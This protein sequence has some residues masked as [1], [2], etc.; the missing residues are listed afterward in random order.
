MN[1]ELVILSNFKIQLV[2]FLDELIEYFPNE[3]DFVIARIF[4]KDQIPIEEI[5]K[6]FCVKLCPLEEMIKNKN[7]KFFIENNILFGGLD[8]DKIGKINYFRELWI[9]G[10]IDED[11]KKIIWSWFSS[12]I[13]L[14]NKYKEITKT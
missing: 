12:F 3:T 13:C 2:N 14:A 10:Q 4:I 5:M 7:E 8:G 1:A 11:N 6:Y 9:S